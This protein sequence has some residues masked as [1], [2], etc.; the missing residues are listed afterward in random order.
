MQLVLTAC[1]QNEKAK[2][3]FVNVSL[4]S[5]FCRMQRHKL[6][7]DL[8]KLAHIGTVIIFQPSKLIQ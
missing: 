6:F 1:K 7:S 3:A 4:S 5:G 2:I 8:N